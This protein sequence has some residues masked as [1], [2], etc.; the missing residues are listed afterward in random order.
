MCFLAAIALLSTAGR[1]FVEAASKKTVSSGFLSASSRSVV[2]RSTPCSTASF[3]SFSAL[4][5]T[6]IGSGITRVPSPS[7]TPPS[8]RIAMTERVRCWF[9]PMRPVTPFMMTPSLCSAMAAYSKLSLPVLPDANDLHRVGSAGL[10]DRL[11]DGEH[12]EVP[13]LHHAVPHQDV[14]VLLE[15]LLAVV[16]D[17]LHHQGIGVAKQRA[18]IARHG[19]RGESV[20]RNAAVDAR[21]PQRGRPRLGERGDRLYL[22]VIGGEKRSHGDRL[23]HASKDAVEEVAV[24]RHLGRVCRYLADAAHGGDGLHRVLAACGFRGQHH[25]VGPVQ[26]GIGDIRYF[27]AR[28]YRA[29]NHRLHHL[30]GG[31]GELV[32]F[33]RMANH[34]FL[35]RRDR[36]VA[37]FDR[38]I[39]ARHHDALASRHDVAERFRLDGL[40]PL[41]LGDEKG[42]SA[43]GAQKLPCHDHIGARLGEGNGEVVHLDFRRGAYVIHVFGWKGGSGE[44]AS[45]PID[46]LVVGEHSPVTDAAMHLVAHDLLYF[47]DDLAVVKKQHVAGMHVAWQLFVVKTHTLLVSNLAVGIEY[48]G[49]AW[50]QSDLAVL[51]LSDP[52]LGALQVAHNADRASGLAAGF[53]HQFGTAL[54]VPRGT[55]REIHAHDVHAREE[56]ALQRLGIARGGAQGCDDFGASW[57]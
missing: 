39:P 43:R 8:L 13:L 56:H 15:Q 27:G 1:S 33:A 17:V 20:D 41:D 25:R 45:E 31:D 36:G 3:F 50:T 52:D 42:V 51:E 29:R 53:A 9:V 28:R 21:H 44:A 35:Q 19:L 57:H 38:Q 16:A 23:V 14:F 22:E 11:T 4:R 54:M 12:D 37:D 34:P 40:R 49:I 5:P 30:R 26:H 6:R 48:K 46:A 2:Q 10:A 47:E 55:M 32:L 7:R 24:E 18:T